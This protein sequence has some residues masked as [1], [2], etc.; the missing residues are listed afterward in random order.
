M[1]KAYFTAYKILRAAGLTH[2]AA[3]AMMGNWDKESLF[4]AFRRQGDL[5]AAAVPSHEYVAAVTSGAISREQFAQ[6][7]I[8]FGLAQ[9]TYHNFSTGKGRK[10]NLYDFWKRSGKALDDPAMQTAFAVCELQNEYSGLYAELKQSDNLY[11][12]T[13]QICKRYEQPEFNN[14]QDRYSAA[15]SIKAVIEAG[16]QAAAEPPQEDKPEIFWPPRMLCLGMN[17]PDVQLLQAS[18]LCHGY[19]AGGCSGIYDNRTKNMVIAFQAENG[20]DVD[21]IAGPKTFK[22]LGI[23]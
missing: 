20:L 1:S 10:L 13:D 8:G 7:Q 6:D 11:Y 9:W 18:L 21:G 23:H 16:E 2:E 14:V 5:S 22:A 3:L 4:D 17:G 19:N 15:L 12:C